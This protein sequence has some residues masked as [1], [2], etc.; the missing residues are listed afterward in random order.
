MPK[1]NPQAQPRSPGVYNQD[2][3]GVRVT[4]Q[5]YDPKPGVAMTVSLPFACS[6]RGKLLP[7]MQTFVTDDE[8]KVVTYLPTSAE[9]RPFQSTGQRKGLIQ[10]KLE[11]EPIGKL[12]FE[13]PNVREW[14]LGA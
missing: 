11:C 14:R 13:V 2:L 4:I 9:V 3:G 7:R 12:A 8:G 5:L 10:Y 1:V 6:W